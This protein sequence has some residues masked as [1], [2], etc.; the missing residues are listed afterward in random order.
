MAAGGKTRVVLRFFTL[1]ACTKTNLRKGPPYPSVVL[2][3]EGISSGLQSLSILCTGGGYY[4]L[5][6]ALLISKLF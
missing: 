1:L 6:T 4:V 5:Y 3:L 2:Y